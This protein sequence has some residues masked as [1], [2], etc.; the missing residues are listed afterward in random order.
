MNK[1]GSAIS[2]E[3]LLFCLPLHCLLFNLNR[4][5]PP[6]NSGGGAGLVG[7]SGD[8]QPRANA[9]PGPG[10]VGALTHGQPGECPGLS[11]VGWV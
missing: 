2:T 4:E 8:V 9:Q 3:E 1:K 7:L 11:A 6:S 10:P 5:V